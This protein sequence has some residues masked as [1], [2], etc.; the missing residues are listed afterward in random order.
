MCEAGIC[1]AEITRLRNGVRSRCARVATGAHRESAVLTLPVLILVSGLNQSVHT[2]GRIAVALTALY[3]DATPFVIGTITALYGLLPTLLAVWAGKLSD[4]IGSRA[5]MF[6]GTLFF[7]AGALVPAIHPSLTSLYFA[8]MLIGLGNMVF[9]VAIQNAVG[10]IGRPE[11]RTRN[12]SSLAIGVSGGAIVGPL[13]A[14]YAIDHLGFEPAFLLL[15][16]CPTLS[17]ALLVFAPLALAKP[18]RAAGAANRRAR[19]LI[20]D[21]KLR[22]VFI[23]TGFQV[24]S[25]ELFT[26]MMPIH[27]TRVGL[28]ASTIGI[29][30]GAFSAATFVIRVVMVRLAA[31]HDPWQIFKGAIVLAAAMFFAMPFATTVWPLAVLAFI[32][33]CG[34]GA[35]QPV[36][37]TLLHEA[38]PPGRAG[39]AVGIRSTVVMSAQTTL[40]LAFGAVGTA[41]GMLPV[42]WA[43]AIMLAAGIAFTRTS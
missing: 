41:T 37:M 2:G 11:D 38:A 13:L 7:T 28:A 22:A 35:A 36:A 21:P 6:A 4:R 18:R 42:F 17:L 34:M 14:G 39:E 5:P 20:A 30:M 33:G 19:D 8:A 15:A 9:Q 12:F 24:M 10:F 40:P 3:L 43:V 23:L 29:V 25:W 32:L 31:R 1:E 16:V 27:G 26:F